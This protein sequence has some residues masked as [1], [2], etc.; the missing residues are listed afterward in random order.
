MGFKNK[1]NKSKK[2]RRTFN[3]NFMFNVLLFLI[4]LIPCMFGKRRLIVQKFFIV[5]L[6]LPFTLLSQRI[7]GSFSLRN[8]Q[9]D[10]VYK[11]SSPEKHVRLFFQNDSEYEILSFDINFSSSRSKIYN[12]IVLKDL[13]RKIVM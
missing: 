2:G 13:N 10:F 6:F 1:L 7:V 9:T 3:I 11:V 8:K 12:K 4:C 5:L